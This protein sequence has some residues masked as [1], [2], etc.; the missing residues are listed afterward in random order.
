M[1]GWIDM[2]CGTRCVRGLG[3]DLFLWERKRGMG[4]KEKVC[5]GL[6]SGGGR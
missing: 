4:G 5:L 2:R 3:F 1:V 6:S